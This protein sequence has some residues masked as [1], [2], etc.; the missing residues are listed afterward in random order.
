[1]RARA[2]LGFAGSLTLIDVAGLQTNPDSAATLWLRADAVG[3]VQVPCFVTAN[4]LVALQTL[5]SYWRRQFPNLQV[6]GVTG[7]VGKTSTKELIR[8]VLK[9]RYRTLKVKAT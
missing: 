7:S 9:Q 3:E 1:M 5:A 2:E 4:S 8:A 6:I